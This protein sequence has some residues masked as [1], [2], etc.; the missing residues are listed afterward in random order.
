MI[1]SFIHF[2]LIFFFVKLLVIYLA[3]HK[4]VDETLLKNVR[5]VMSG[6]APLGG[7]DVERFFKK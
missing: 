4:S 2:R 3:Q 6:A 7:T 1:Q 5:T